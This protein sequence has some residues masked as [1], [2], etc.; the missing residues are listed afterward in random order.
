MRSERRASSWDEYFVKMAQLAAS[1]SKDQSTKCGAIIVGPDNEVVST[2]FNGFPRN[3]NEDIEDRWERPQKYEWTEHG[4]R[5]AIFNAARVG[6]STRGCKMY[7][8]YQV[9][10]CSDCTRAIIQAGIVEVIGPNIKFPGKGKGTHYDA[11]G[12]NHIMLDE[13]EIKVVTVVD[14]TE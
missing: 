7:M 5:N 13:A 3:V 14:I 1:K 11:C 12:V 2:G 6:V 8:N 9:E 4:E 10:C